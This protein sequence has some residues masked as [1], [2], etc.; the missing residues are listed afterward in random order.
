[1]SSWGWGGGGA[2]RK[3]QRQRTERR[4]LGDVLQER[5]RLELEPSLFTGV[6]APGEPRAAPALLSGAPS[7]AKDVTM[8][9]R[10]SR[11]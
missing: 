3:A 8:S 7:A 10:A 4:T 11:L 6:K 5:L 2:E 9:R 1:M